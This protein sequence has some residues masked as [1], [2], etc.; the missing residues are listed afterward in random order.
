MKK[1]LLAILISLSF[2]FFGSSYAAAEVVICGEILNIEYMQL[3]ESGTVDVPVQPCDLIIDFEHPIADTDPVEYQLW[4]NLPVNANGTQLNLALLKFW[5]AAEFPLSA[6]VELYWNSAAA[7][8]S[9]RIIKV[10]Y[11]SVPPAAAAK[12]A[13]ILRN[14]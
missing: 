8:W 12:R 11:P 10:D 9:I 13:F 1:S 14:K 3:Y 4:D 6:C 7:E 5:N 2:V